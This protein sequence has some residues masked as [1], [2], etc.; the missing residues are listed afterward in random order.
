MKKIVIFVCII[1]ISITSF[2]FYWF[3]DSPQI[4]DV[5]VTYNNTEYDFTFP[6][7]VSWRDYLIIKSNWEGTLIDRSGQQKIVG[8]EIFIRH[9]LWTSTNPRQ[10]IPIMIFTHEQ[11]IL[12]QQDKLSLGAAPIPPNELWRNNQYVFALPARYNFAFLPGYEEVANII[13]SIITVNNQ[14]AST[15]LNLKSTDPTFQHYIEII[16]GCG[17]YYNTSL[18]VNMRS[19]PGLNYPVVSRLRTGVVLKVEN[20][21]IMDG[22][23][24]WHKIIFDKEIRYPER[25]PSQGWYVAVD[26]TSVRSILN[27][28]DEVLTSK[29]VTTSK[30]IIVSLSQEMLYA[31][32]G[33]ILFMQNPISTG[34]E[35]TPTPAGL[36]KIFKKTPSRYMQGPILTV[37]DDYYDLPGVPWNLYFTVDGAVIHGAYWHDRFGQPW[38]HGCVNLPPD[39]AKKLY[40]WVDIGTIVKVEK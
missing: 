2:V 20:T 26:E 3:Y 25:V 16:D 7:P 36:F 40:L 30:R 21:N 27:I 22:N 13:Q 12:I 32:D 23:L 10:D 24:S 15:T 34:L 38:S 37:S 4:L 35:F 6:L 8:P 17:P 19:G 14:V 28:G 31:Y 11:W 1:I 29:S 5:Q 18:C 9:P 39:K 33:D